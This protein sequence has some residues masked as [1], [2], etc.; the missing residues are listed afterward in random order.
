MMNVESQ[1]KLAAKVMKIGI[2]R[3]RVK[4]TKEVAD[5]ITRGDIRR[6]IVHGDIYSVQ[7]TGTTRIH[8]NIIRT[9][10]K[11]GRQRGAGSRKGVLSSKK[12]VWMVK[13]RSLRKMLNEMRDEKKIDGKTYRKLY[14]NVKGG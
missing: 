10:K 6:L 2:S 8:A 13:V 12:E 9:Q 1:K 14:L 11:K 7:K 3:V 4:N 5:A